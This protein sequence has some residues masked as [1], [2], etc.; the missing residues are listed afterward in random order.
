MG[1]SSIEWTK[2]VWNPVTGCVKISPG[3]KFC[4]AETFAERWRGI[5]GHP[6]EQGFDLKLW[7]ERLLLP[8][9]WNKPQKIFVNSMSDLFHDDVP[10]AFI[11]RVFAVMAC[12]PWHTYQLLTKRQER[13]RKYL[14]DP[15]VAER[16]LLQCLILPKK[17]EWTTLAQW[18][19]KNVWLGVSVESPDFQQR[20]DD[21]L[22]TPAAVRWISAEPL[23]AR[24]NLGMYLLGRAFRVTHSQ[25][26]APDGAMVGRFTRVGDWWEPKLP[27]LDW[28]VVG[29]ESGAGAR[30]FNVAWANDIKEECQL[31]G[32]PVF[33]K[34]LG[35]RVFWDGCTVQWQGL[36][37]NASEDGN[38]DGGV[39]W[40]VR[41]KDKKGGDMAEWPRD[42]RVR[43]FPQ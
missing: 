32:V 28:V 15:E 33:V 27:R 18:P 11:D 8:L 43:E 34:Q 42:L 3:C 17:A 39:G 23:L 20:I 10:A 37:Q 1:E 30:P 22:R 6:Y 7:P 5:K 41:L 40:W 12:S 19:L 26:D 35:R 25:H 4:Y 24:L 2:K 21:L 38:F 16:V 31:A 9:G 36:G 14:S 29:G 13:M